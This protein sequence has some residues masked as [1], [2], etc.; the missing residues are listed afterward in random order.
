VPSGGFSYVDARDV[1]EM[2]VA[3]LHE[4]EDGQRYL[5]SSINLTCSQFFE[6]LTEVSGV[7]GPLVNVK[8]PRRFARLGVALLEKAAGA[9]GMESPINELEADMASHF[10]YVDARKAL[11]TVRDIR[12]GDLSIS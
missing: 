8:V 1:G 4:G 10:W 7:S 9:V 12:G 5:L 6:R 11:D 2:C 3:A